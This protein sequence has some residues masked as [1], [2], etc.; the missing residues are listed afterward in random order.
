[1]SEDSPYGQILTLVGAALF[2]HRHLFCSEADLQDFYEHVL[3]FDVVVVSDSFGCEAAKWLG[4][5]VEALNLHFQGR[6]VPQ[7]WEGFQRGQGWKY[8]DLQVTVKGVVVEHIREL[9][10][11]V[12]EMKSELEN[13]KAK[14]EPSWRERAGAVERSMDEEVDK[15]SSDL[16]SRF[17]VF[18]EQ[19]QQTRSSVWRRIVKAVLSC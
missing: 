11:N 12:V 10:Q 7:K 9:A 19:D 13:I 2:K 8:H 1:M 17:R 6:I 3:S 4:V 14:R 18:P 5:P 16:K 15:M